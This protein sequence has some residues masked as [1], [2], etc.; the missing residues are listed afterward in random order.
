MGEREREY[1]STR[2]YDIYV[3]FA[4]VC[5]RLASSTSLLP[6]IIFGTV[7]IRDLFRSLLELWSS[8]Q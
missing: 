8:A 4:I 2:N 7:A 5:S 6:S 1:G 3:R